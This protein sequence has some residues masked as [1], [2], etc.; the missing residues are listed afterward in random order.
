MP[1]PFSFL[2]ALC[3]PMAHEPPRCLLA[4][5]MR[6]PQTPSWG[7]PLSFFDKS[8]VD[9]ELNPKRQSN[10]IRDLARFVDYCLWIT[11]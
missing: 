3:A 2:L 10:P 4:A 9:A 7:V 11:F 1:P 8:A 5:H 6:R